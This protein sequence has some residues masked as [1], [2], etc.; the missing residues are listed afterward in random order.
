[1]A[2]NLLVKSASQ[3]YMPAINE[4]GLN[5]YT[6]TLLSE[7]KEKALELWE[8]AERINN[9]EA[10]TRIAAGNIFG[11]IKSEEISESIKSLTE[12]SE[13]GSVLA[14]VVLAY[15]Y[16]NGIGLEQSK[17]EAVKYFRFAAQRG[18]RFAF[19][20]LKR[21]YDEIRPDDSEFRV[22]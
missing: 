4:L 16:E 19:K 6:G 13:D 11:E 12:T 5:Y 15:A 1:D 20:E 8:S 17:S 7:D 18:N 10:K 14:Q 2:L 3:G 21:I 9:P 22:N